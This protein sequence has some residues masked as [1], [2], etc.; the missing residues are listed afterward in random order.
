YRTTESTLDDMFV[1][2]NGEMAPLSQFVTLKRVYGSE[3]LSRFNLYN[4]ITVNAS[5]ADGYS[6]GDAIAEVARVSQETLPNNFSYSYGG[7]TREEASQSNNTAIIFGICIFFIYLILCAMY[8][9][10]LLP[11][12]VILSVP[13]GLM[14]SFLF[15]HMLGLENNIYLQVGLIMLIGLI[16][17]TA[18]LLT[19]YAVDRRMKG[20]TL[21]QAALSAA[22]ARLRPILMTASTMI[23]GLLPLM[24]AMGV[25]ANG[26]RSLGSGVVGGMLFGTV[27]LLIVV[28]VFFIIFQ[29]LQERI[30]PL[31]FNSDNQHEDNE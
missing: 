7:I 12:A 8:E 18:I 15:A 5:P 28:P 25:G 3:T 11:F 22:K 9:S 4:S 21:A 16:S 23:I 17:K 30:K 31:H 24:T 6:T 2:I 20:M 14:G 19:E 26:N 1:R 10:F 29:S 13:F 27:A